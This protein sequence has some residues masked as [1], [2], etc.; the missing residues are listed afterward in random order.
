MLPLKLYP[1]F[2]ARQEFSKL[3]LTLKANCRLP[4]QLR[5]KELTVRFRVPEFVT[6]VYIHEKNQKHLPATTSVQHWQDVKSISSIASYA[7]SYVESANQYMT[8]QPLPQEND[9]ADF[10]TSK[11]R[12]EWI[13]KNFRGG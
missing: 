12:I 10:N 5:L 3:D 8:K 2:V 6:R 7:S 4:S 13:V 11:R 9:V 1:T